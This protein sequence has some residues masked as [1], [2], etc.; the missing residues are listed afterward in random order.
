MAVL[1]VPGLTPP[2]AR[3]ANSRRTEPGSAR[4]SNPARQSEGTTSNPTP[5]SS[6][7]PAALAWPS[8]RAIVSNTPISP[9]TSR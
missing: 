4:A 1:A 7:T 5:G 8:S 3:R 2:E 6:I 9:V